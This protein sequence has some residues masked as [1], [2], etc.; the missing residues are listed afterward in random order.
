MH[1]FLDKVDVKPVKANDAKQKQAKKVIEY[2][3]ILAHAENAS[4]VIKENDEDDSKASGPDNGSYMWPQSSAERASSRHLARRRVS[5]EIVQSSSLI[6]TAYLFGTWLDFD[7]L[8]KDRYFERKLRK[9]YNDDT[10]GMGFGYNAM[11]PSIS[12]VSVGGGGG[13]GA[14]R[15]TNAVEKHNA[16]VNLKTIKTHSGGD[17]SDT[18]DTEENELLV[19]QYREMRTNYQWLKPLIHGQCECGASAR[20]SLGMFCFLFCCFFI[21][22]YFSF[23]F[24]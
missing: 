19:E 2:E 14:T 11:S 16:S 10:I 23:T 7:Q 1:N 12:S 9:K 18:S 24:F 3:K 4:N 15:A 5:M 22:I 20:R 17:T 6:P 13:Y 8:A 21:F